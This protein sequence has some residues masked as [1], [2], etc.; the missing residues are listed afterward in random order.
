MAELAAVC[1]PPA[2]AEQL[3]PE[4]ERKDRASIKKLMR[5]GEQSK[6]LDDSQWGFSAHQE[7]WPLITM[8]AS[9]G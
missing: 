9:A 8:L 4:R 2:P 6:V 5:E 7:M 1:C 3:T